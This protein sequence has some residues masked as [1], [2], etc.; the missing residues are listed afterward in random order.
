[1]YVRDREIKEETADQIVV[2]DSVLTIGCV[3]V[4]L[5][6]IVLELC[7]VGIGVAM[8]VIMWVETG[9]WLI[10]S[11][12]WLFAIWMGGY[13]MLETLKELLIK[14]TFTI[15]RKHQSVIIEKDSFIKCLKSI[16]K[17]SFLDIEHIE[18]RIDID[19]GKVTGHR[20]ISLITI[21]G[22]KI[23]IYDGDHVPTEKLAKSIRDMTTRQIARKNNCYSSASS[24]G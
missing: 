2:T 8:F 7:C 13:G 16:K 1:M 10:S 11:I 15:D 21:H 9:H 6:M 20:D 4:G 22:K 18:M 3:L 12:I 17:I 24:A 23:N 19:D 5:F 14:K